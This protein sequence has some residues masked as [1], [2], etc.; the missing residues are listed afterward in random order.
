MN[1][2]QRVLSYLFEGQWNREKEVRSLYGKV[3]DILFNNRYDIFGKMNTHD[4]GSGFSLYIRAQRK[5][6]EKSEPDKILVRVSDHRAND[7][8]DRDKPNYILIVGNNDAK[9]LSDFEQS[10]K[11]RI[12]L[13]EAGKL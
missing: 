1:F 11:L 6:K 2:K 9:T 3:E 13:G 4:S 5:Y 8:P 7:R 12:E 10:I